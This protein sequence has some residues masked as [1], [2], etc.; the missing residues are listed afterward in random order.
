MQ[1]LATGFQL[2]FRNSRIVC[3]VFYRKYGQNL[4]YFFLYTACCILV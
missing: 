1:K 3:A 4:R 2:F